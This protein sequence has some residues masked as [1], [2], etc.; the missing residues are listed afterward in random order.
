MNPDK[1]VKD[2]D[3]EETGGITA[4]GLRNDIHEHRKEE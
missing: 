4:E 3:K 1:F 2:L